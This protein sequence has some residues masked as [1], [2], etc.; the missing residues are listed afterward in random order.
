MA[1]NAMVTNN[2][3][4]PR[5]HAFVRTPGGWRLSP[6]YD[7]VPVAL[8][9]LERRDLA[10]EA[11]RYGRMASLYNL[12]SDCASFGLHL[13]DAQQIIDQMVAVVKDWREL[14]ARH[15]VQQRSIEFIS[16]AILPEC[17]FR[18]QPILAG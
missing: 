4:H 11:G 6:A 7:I 1:F 18:K 13:E 9:S 15:Q 5:N 2:D 14:F 16:G 10:L 3:D 17:F 8:I 12:L